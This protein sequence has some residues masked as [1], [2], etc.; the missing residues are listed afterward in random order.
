MVLKELPRGVS[1]LEEEIDSEESLH[2]IPAGNQIKTP[3]PHC[4]VVP[5][6]DFG[7]EDSSQLSG[8]KP[9][10][11]LSRMRGTSWHLKKHEFLPAR[12]AIPVCLATRLPSV[13][14]ADI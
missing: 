13:F 14:G 7:P 1:A 8:T 2:R 3:G 11:P 12:K 10:N 5:K 6:H 4:Q 9:V